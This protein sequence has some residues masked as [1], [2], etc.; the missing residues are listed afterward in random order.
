MPDTTAV[1]SR[2][3]KLLIYSVSSP[4]LTVAAGFGALGASESAQA[5]PL[6]LIPPDTVDHYD[7]G[8]SLVQTSL[9]T[10]PLVRLQVGTDGRATLF[11]PRLE[12]GQGIATLA[13]MLVAEE[14]D[15]PLEM[16]D[17]PHE[18]G[19]PELV[20]NQIS[21]GSAAA[22]C[23][24][25]GLPLIAAVARA[26]LIAAAARRLGVDGAS[27]RVQAGV[28]I[29]ADGRQ[30]TYAELSAEAATLPTP[31]G[32]VPKS[33]SQYRLIGTPAPRL[34]AR[35]IVTGRK[36]FAMDLD[37]AG[38]KPTMVRMPSQIRGTVVQ[39]HNSAAVRAMPGVIDVV[40]IPPGGSIVPRPPAVAVMAET[41]GEAWDALNALEI[42]WGDGPLAGQSDATIMDRLKR[43]NPPLAIPPLGAL[44]VEG[45]FEWR[46]AAHCPLE[47]ETAIADVR[48]DRCEIWAAMQSP[49]ITLQSVAADLGLRQDQVIAHVVPAGGSFGRRL[50][51]DPVQI[52]VQVSRL[53]GRPCKL[54][55]H[56]SDDMRHTRVRPPQVHKVRATLLLG[57]VVGYEQ[58]VAAVRLDARHGY[59]EW[60]TAS[61][62]SLPP[63]VQQ[64][65]GNLGYEQF[66]FK[67]MVAS[68]YNFGTS[69]KLLT[70]VAIDMN[71]VSFRSVHIQPARCCE[72]IIVDEIAARLRKDPLAF[73]LE[74]LRLP[75]AR[76][77]LQRVAE[78]IGWGRSLPAGTALGIAAHQE[79]RSFTACAVELDAR[80][81]GRARVVRAVIAIDVGR[82]INPSGIRAQCEGGLADAIT[83]V[84]NAGLTVRDGLPLES[85][86][87]NY[88]VT[89]MRDFPGDVE[90]IVMPDVGEPIGGMGEVG[91]AAAS[92]AIAN[93]WARA[94]GRKP[95][96]FPLNAPPAFVPVP[97]GRL[98][99]PAHRL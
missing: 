97:P 92:A 29:A 64:T 19:R 25:A 96:K 52:A 32:V 27:L 76:A 75:R 68:P 37:V 82:P 42:T 54:M 6:P 31:A 90:I 11:L 47:V 74:H 3:R 72:E 81:P 91:F 8:D 9:P 5:T 62:G 78:A 87:S 7:I 21:G 63:G 94:T 55:Y 40:V 83:V 85:S 13:G 1:D 24:S 14:L 45:E 53:T 28:V 38:A 65:V 35:D 84:L 4:V 15:L 46:A 12:T 43:S 67:T 86:Y 56:R 20:F 23:L 30:L 99:I 57:Q 49:I 58:N 34:D 93:A 39:I 50:F 26:R 60:V 36:R 88:P 2:R 22:R 61:G 59:G 17:V 51:W 79:S 77:V 71:T 48:P 66:F 44:T 41:F 95:R 73:R 98:P 16:V 69:K 18:D 33:P 80:T 10:M 89:R 70:P